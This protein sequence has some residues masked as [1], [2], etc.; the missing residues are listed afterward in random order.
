MT[1]GQLQ[2]VA[3]DIDRVLE[4]IEEDTYGVC[5]E[6]G[7]PI[8]EERLGARVKTPCTDPRAL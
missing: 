5:D 2:Q 3:A 7:Q 1:A 8:G 4:K 6:C